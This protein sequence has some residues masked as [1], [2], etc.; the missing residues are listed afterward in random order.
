MRVWFT[1]AAPTL[2]RIR[3]FSVSI[4]FFVIKIIRLAKQHSFS[5]ITGAMFHGYIKL[6]FYDTLLLTKGMSWYDG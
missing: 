1:S 5:I 6:L 2:S 4:P 3:W